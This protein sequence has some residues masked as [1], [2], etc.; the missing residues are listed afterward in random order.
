MATRDVDYYLSGRPLDA[1][2]QLGRLRGEDC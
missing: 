2:C 1:D